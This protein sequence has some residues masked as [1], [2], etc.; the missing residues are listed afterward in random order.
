MTTMMRALAPLSMMVLLVGL[1]IRPASA[2]TPSV[3]R[4]VNRVDVLSRPSADSAVVATVE[5]G[6]TLDVVDTD[7]Q[8]IQV[9]LRADGSS[10]PRRGWVRAADAEAVQASDSPVGPASPTDTTPPRRVSMRGG[11]PPT[12]DEIRAAKRQRDAEARLEQEQQARI[13]VAR[14]NLERL[15]QEYDDVVQHVGGSGSS[16]AAQSPAPVSRSIQ[17]AR[18]PFDLFGGYS[19][20][21]DNSDSLTFPVGWIASIGRQLNARLSIVG[22]ASGSYKSA[23]VTGV[24]LASASVH[25]FAAGPRFSTASRSL[26]VYGQLLGGAAAMTGS[27]LGFSASSAGLALEPGFGVDVQFTRGLAVRAGGEWPIVRDSGA[28]FNGFRLTTGLVMRSRR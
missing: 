20:L 6:A 18:P 25:T 19:L 24:T 2:E 11:I 27:V 4:I 1:A 17:P 23:G 15:Q 13:D 21:F 10:E 28:W 5:A 3:V 16:D 9:S 26:V 22:E 8:W 12:G 7:G 14:Q